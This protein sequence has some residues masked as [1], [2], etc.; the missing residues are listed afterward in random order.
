MSTRGKTLALQRELP[1]GTFV[2]AVIEG[3]WS[4]G[5]VVGHR[6]GKVRVESPVLMTRYGLRATGLTNTILKQTAKVYDVD[7]SLARQVPIPESVAPYRE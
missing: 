2:N 3:K 4:F 5:W 7:P 6:A 1:E